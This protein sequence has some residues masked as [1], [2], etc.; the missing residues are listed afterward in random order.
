MNQKGAYKTLRWAEISGTIGG[1]LRELYRMGII[2]WPRIHIA[3]HRF[4]GS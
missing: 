4:L 1:I 2:C 3:F